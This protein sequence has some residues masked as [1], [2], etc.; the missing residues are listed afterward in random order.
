MYFSGFGNVPAVARRAELDVRHGD[1][2][3]QPLRL[4]ITRYGLLRHHV[5]RL[6]VETC[7]NFPERLH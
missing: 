1:D 2:K 5:F 7:P 6:L 3:F 4:T